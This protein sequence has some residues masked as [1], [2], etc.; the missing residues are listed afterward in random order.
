MEFR[1]LGNTDMQLSVISFGASSLG[2]EFVPVDLQDA[3]QSVPTAL[4]CGMNFIDTSPYYGRG[5]GEVLLGIALKGI[6]R[7]QYYLGTKLGRY[8]ESHFEFSAKRVRES[9]DVSLH[10]LGTDY[11]DIILCHDIEFVEMQQVVDE[12]IPAL[13]EIQQQGKVRYIGM[14]GYPMKIFKFVLDQT[15]LDVVL[16]YNHYTLQNTMFGDLAPYL[17]E[18]GVG[19]LNAAPFSAR[20]LTNAGL[21]PW[22]KATDQVRNICKQAA[23]HCSQAGIDIAQLA[24]QYSIANQDM[25]TCV[26]GS[27]NPGRIR[28][29]ADW[30]NEPLDTQLV[31]EVQEILKPIHNWFYIEGREE[32]NDTPII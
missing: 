3:L 6:P 26:T 18:K 15:D 12:T 1:Q 28:Q 24:L 5:I 17:K 14:S 13:R 9:V 20:L 10:R 27:A 4:D 31:S 8:H 29:W 19:I 30:I 25:T 22:H 7:D 2:S 16:S 11:L 21:P 32:N 23:D